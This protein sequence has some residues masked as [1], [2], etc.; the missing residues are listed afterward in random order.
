MDKVLVLM[1]TYNGEKYLREAIDSIL[2]QTNVE[3]S[4]LV[5]DD[6][7][8]DATQDILQKYQNQ[9]KLKW[10][11]GKNLGAQMSFMDLIFQAEEGWDFY[12]F[13]DQDDVWLNQKLSKAIEHLSKLSA[14]CRLYTGTPQFVDESLQPVAAEYK[15]PSKP[16]TFPQAFIK[17]MAIGCT[18]V[19]D[20]ALLRMVKAYRPKSVPM[21]D[22]WVYLICLGMGGKLFYDHEPYLLYRRHEN[23]ASGEK[24]SFDRWKARFNRLFQEKGSI[25]NIALEF[26]RGFGNVLS[27]NDKQLLDRILQYKGSLK[28]KIALLSES[29]FKF[30]SISTKS[31]DMTDLM[32]AIRGLL[33]TA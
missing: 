4:L 20:E 22:R 18:M 11:C 9:N 30:S 17:N 32:F 28:G 31:I 25:F 3:V 33:G 26:D 5:R 2:N 8:K 21:H 6:G 15:I 19:M 14:P 24:K 1:S 13:A 7:S 10:Y 12:A 23:N 29:E 16:Y 27:D